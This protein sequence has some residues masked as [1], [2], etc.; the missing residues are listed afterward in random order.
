MDL[1]DFVEESNRIEGITRIQSVLLDEIA[2]H[3]QFLNLQMLAIENVDAFV[4]SVQPGAVLRD[5]SGLDVRVVDHIA[6]PGGP[7]IRED[8][9][10]LLRRINGH[11]VNPFDAHV[12]YEN[13]HPFTDG[14]GRSGRVIWL[15]M[16]GTVAPL[17]FLHQFYYETLLN[18]RPTPD[19]APSDE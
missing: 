15:W 13:L 16:H 12:E 5:K 2:I 18:S 4:M 6:P 7:A 8:L 19:T 14:N 11:K 3:Q 10:E 17:G 1:Y 9:E